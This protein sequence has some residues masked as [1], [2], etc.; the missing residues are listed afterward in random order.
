MEDPTEEQI[1]KMGEEQISDKEVEN[2]ST[3]N[4]PKKEQTV[5]PPFL[6]LYIKR[7]C[8]TKLESTIFDYS[9][10]IEEYESYSTIKDMISSFPEIGQCEI[11]MN[12]LRD[13]SSSSIKGIKLNILTNN[14]F[15]GSCETTIKRSS[16]EYIFSK[17]IS[18]HI[19]N[20][21]L[22]IEFL[23]QDIDLGNSLIINCKFEI[24]CKL[25]NNIIHMDLLPSSTKLSKNVTYFKDPSFDMFEYKNEESI[26]F[27]IGGKPHVISKK[28]LC[29]TNSSYFK[30]ICF[31][32]EIEKDMT[33]ELVT[34]KEK[35]SFY[36]I[37]LYIAT[38]SIEQCDYDM[39]K[40]LLT[41]A[42]KYD[43]QSLKS[44]CEHYLLHVI[45]IYN[46]MDLI[47]LALLS[48]AKFL[49]THSAT[50]I[51]IHIEVIKN[52]K[53]YRDLPQENLIKIMELIEKSKLPEVSIH[54]SLLPFKADREL[55]FANIGV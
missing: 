24:F 43:V 47:E 51:K 41:A 50:F 40:Q 5:S 3:E 35:R 54:L 28:S 37:L 34:D 12:V 21:T 25:I 55:T 7:C 11:L 30:N 4:T 16:G 26:K 29:A 46:A 1:H 13:N 48:N 45:S 31:T 27:I 20:M 14:S 42:D 15:H 52:T 44:T 8:I 53:Q 19:S 23:T 32:Q 2:V 17:F 36:Q 18:G 9:W 6:P 22:L 49:E 33:N 38:G 39:L 10:T